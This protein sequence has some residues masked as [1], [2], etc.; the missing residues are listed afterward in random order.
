VLKPESLNLLYDKQYLEKLREKVTDCR[1]RYR[2]VAPTLVPDSLLETFVVFRNIHFEVG[3]YLLTPTAKRQLD[4]IS[5]TRLEK[6]AKSLQVSGH[7]DIQSFKGVSPEESDYRNWILSQQRAASVT[8]ALAKRGIP[9]N[10]II[11]KGYGYTQPAQGYTKADW[12]K[13]R[14]VEIEVE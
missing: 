1:S 9:I 3:K 4:E 5:N 8:N 10:R 7:T 14:R 6:G 11:T 13:N 2:S 12:D